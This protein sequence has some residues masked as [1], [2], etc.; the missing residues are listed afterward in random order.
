[1]GAFPS[2]SAHSRHPK[3]HCPP[4]AGAPFP[5]PALPLLTLQPCFWSRPASHPGG[6]CNG[7]TCGLE[8]QILAPP[9]S[10]CV[11]WC[12]FLNF[13][14]S[15]FLICKVEEITDRQHRVTV[16]DCGHTAAGVGECLVDVGLVTLTHNPHSSAALPSPNVRCPARPSQSA[17][18]LSQRPQQSHGAGTLE[19]AHW[20]H[21]DAE[22][23]LALTFKG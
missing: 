7:D 20:L 19:E 15:H 21:Q 18:S 22:K 16:R 5:A 6:G 3:T 2:L 8:S 4:R 13:S 14:V 11:V 17:P 12:Q 9:S 10:S 23:S 1:M